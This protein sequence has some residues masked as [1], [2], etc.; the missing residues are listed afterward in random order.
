MLN[1]SEYA[2]ETMF[3]ANATFQNTYPNRTMPTEN[4][5]LY[6]PPGARADLWLFFYIG[7]QNY[8]AN[9]IIQ[10]STFKLQALTF[11]EYNYGGYYEGLGAYNCQR[12][13]CQNPNVELVIKVQ[14]GTPIL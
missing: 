2:P 9:N 13:T 14:T 8:Q 4:G 11:T 12:V 7:F 10:A 6:L 1:G 5:G 3:I